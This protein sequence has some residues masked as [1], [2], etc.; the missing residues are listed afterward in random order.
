[1]TALIALRETP[2]DVSEAQ[3]A[4]ANAG[5]GAIVTFVGQVRNNSGGLPVTKLEYE[6]YPSMALKE[7]NAIGQEIE[8]AFPGTRVALLHR[9]GT[10]NVG[11]A[12]VVCAA[13]AAHR[14]EAFDACHLLID[15]V[16]ARAP[17]WK[18]EHGPNGPYW[19]GW[20][21]A[22]CGAGRNAA[23]DSQASTSL[24][25]SCPEDRETG[26]GV[27][28][29]AAPPP[30]C[31][32]HCGISPCG[33][34]ARPEGG[35]LTK[36]PG[37]GSEGLAGT[38]ISCV[39]VS[40]TRTLETD[41]SGALIERLFAAAGATTQRYLVR[42]DA[43]A[44]AN[45]V[46]SLVSSGAGTIILSGGTGIGPRDVTPEA[47]APLLER[48]IDGFGEAFRHLSFV[49]IGT[50]ALLSRAIAGLCRQSLIFV[51]PGSK[52][53][54]RLAVEEL[55]LPVLPHARAMLQGKGH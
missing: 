22:R 36:I 41:G 20:D 38:R 19:V 8:A 52:E 26:P 45:L 21:D 48:Q 4:V 6:A 14:K 31:H 13:S 28:A 7:M 12:A 33:S 46:E 47:V 32:E 18:R 50:R 1:M 51:L 25:G 5:A 23:L 37:A 49:A 2:L 44:I 17:I 29:S 10:L 9:I 24:A 3:N 30:S 42:D 15:Q 16:K 27:D 54:A 11:D 35:E 34:P 55:I 43:S 39:T 53:A 40:D